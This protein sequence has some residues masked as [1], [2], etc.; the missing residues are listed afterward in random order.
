M[1]AVPGAGG[2]KVQMVIRV[3]KVRLQEVV[4]HILGRKF[5]LDPVDPQAFK[6]QH[7]HGA[8]GILKQGLVYLDGDFFSWCKFPLHQMVQQ[9]FTGKI[10]RHA[11][12]SLFFVRPCS[13]P[14]YLRD[15][16]QASCFRGIIGVFCI[17][18]P[19]R[20]HHP[21]R[22]PWP[23][24]C[25]RVV[26]VRQRVDPGLQM[27]P[28]LELFIKGDATGIDV[29]EREPRVFDAF[30]QRLGNPLRVTCKKPGRKGSAVGQD[31]QGGVQ[32]GLAASLGGDLGLDPWVNWGKAG[33]WSVHRSNC[34]KGGSSRRC[35]ALRYG[36]DAR[37]RWQ[38]RPHPLPPRRTVRAGLPSFTPVATGRDLP[39]TVCSP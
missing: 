14:L 23:P 15:N 8:G 4:I 28:G 13:H 36:A 1:D 11:V 9:D 37:R 21:G 24:S 18:Y 10:F 34:R 2:L 35:P 31:H 39:C 17:K 5:R 33:P 38:G 16:G 6:G 29:K 7:G 22:S 25:R 19:W 12:P 20:I 32:R 30:H 26:M 3:L 27:F